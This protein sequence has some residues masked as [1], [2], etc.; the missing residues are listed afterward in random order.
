M[1]ASEEKVE[2]GDIFLWKTG[3]QHCVVVKLPE[4]G[5][6]VEL[7]TVELDKYEAELYAMLLNTRYYKRVA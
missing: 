5:E 3:E 7:Y 4:E 1:T 2:V 6:I